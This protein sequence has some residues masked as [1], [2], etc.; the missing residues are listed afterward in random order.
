[1][2]HVPAVSVLIPCYNTARYLRQTVESV[3][4]QTCADFELIL[5]DDGSSDS[6]KQLLGELRQRDPRIRTHS[7]DNNGIVDTRNELLSMAHG[8]FI[9]WHDSDDLMTPCRLERQLARFHED[10]SLVWVGGACA[11]TDPEGLPIRTHAFPE[12]HAAICKIME[13]EIGCYFGSTL[14]RRGTI[15]KLGG[16]RQPFRISEDFDLVLRMSEVGRVA[17]IPEVV[18]IYR[19]HMA[20]TAN[21]GRQRC[22]AYSRLVRQLA[23]ER[24]ES[25]TDRLQRGE[26]VDLDFTGLPSEKSN[27][28]ETHRRWAWWAL[29]DG[30]L[31]TARKYALHSLREAPLALESWKLLACSVRG[32]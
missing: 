22:A 32:H 2:P 6:T 26:P 11:L 29:Q 24:R 18:L 14:M 31:K 15:E 27:R 23:A 4:A 16:F 17:N 30:H 13:I 9:S 25:G 10:P 5:L 20:S 8:Q 12:D 3:L 21:H 28:I 1:M 7:R 19:Q